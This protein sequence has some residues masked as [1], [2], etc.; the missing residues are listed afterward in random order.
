MKN[1]ILGILLV[2]AI[3]FGASAF[4][5]DHAKPVGAGGGGAAG[6][7]FYTSASSATSSVTTS[8]SSTPV[9]SADASR[10]YVSFCNEN[11]G[12]G[13]GIYLGLGATSSGISGIKIAANSCY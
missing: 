9:L 13:N 12:S 8:W 5:Q 4:M 1:L 10:G 2:L 11:T 3:G 6:Q 7:F